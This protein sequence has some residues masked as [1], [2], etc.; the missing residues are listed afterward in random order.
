MSASVR[1][2][3]MKTFLDTVERLERGSS[4]EVLSHFGED[5]VER[6][7]SAGPTA[8]LPAELN[9][10]LTHAV[11]R[12]LGPDETEGFFR[13]MLGLVYDTSLFSTFV[14]GIVRLVGRDPGGYLKWVARGY[15]LAFKNAG[16]WSV[17]EHEAGRAVL[18]VSGLPAPFAGDEVWLRT[19]AASMGSLFDLAQKPG[20]SRLESYGDDH[21]RI[22]LSWTE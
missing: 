6:I 18:A 2:R 4:R 12:T 5:A 10:Q 9:V 3:Y 7:R 20:E 15:S 11:A 13:H 1:A 19:V 22:V 14:R 21:A 16:V 8:W 17:A